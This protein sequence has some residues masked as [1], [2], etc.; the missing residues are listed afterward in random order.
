MI[1]MINDAGYTMPAETFSTQFHQVTS[2]DRRSEILIILVGNLDDIDLDFEEI[3][4]AGKDGEPHK[5]LAARAL[6]IAQRYIQVDVSQTRTQ[7]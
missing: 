1:K 5:Q 6:P 4:K 2:P 3:V 7:R